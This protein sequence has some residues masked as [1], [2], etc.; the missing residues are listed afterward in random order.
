MPMMVSD[1][2]KLGL[3]IIVNRLRPK[4]VA[5]HAGISRNYLAKLRYGRAEPTRLV[6]IAIAAACTFL[7]RRRVTVS[8][9]FDLEDKD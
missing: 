9:L 1:L 3:F 7:L 6:M 5:D 8:E 4:N 2:T